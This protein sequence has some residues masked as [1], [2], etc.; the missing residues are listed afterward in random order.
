MDNVLFQ[1]L[2]SERLSTSIKLTL[3]KA[4]IRLVMAYACPTWEFA[5]DIY[6]LKLQRPQNKVL[7]P[8]GIFQDAHRP[9]ICTRLSKVC[10]YTIM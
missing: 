5:A 10:M 1:V 4:L 3:H 8:I 9:T 6:L 2:K 7:R